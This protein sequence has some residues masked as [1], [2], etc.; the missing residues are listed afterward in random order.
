MLPA[1]DKC[2]MVNQYYNIILTTDTQ[3]NIMIFDGRLIENVL[4][5]YLCQMNL[6]Y[7]CNLLLMGM[8]FFNQQ[9]ISLQ[10]VFILINIKEYCKIISLSMNIPVSVRVVH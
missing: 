2:V 6:R 4:N 7:R 9:P 5:D 3:Q 1:Y 8:I 10:Q